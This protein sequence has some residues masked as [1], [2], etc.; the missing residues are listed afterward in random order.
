[1]CWKNY[2]YKWYYLDVPIEVLRRKM[3]E[4]GNTVE[5]R[6]EYIKRKGRA[7]LAEEFRNDLQVREVLCPLI[8][9]IGDF[10][11]KA[12]LGETLLKE[13]LMDEW[14]GNPIV[15]EVNI[16]VGALA[17]ACGYEAL[18]DKLIQTGLLGLFIAGI[19]GAL[20]TSKN[21]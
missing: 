3:I 10:Q 5:S 14:F 7:G 6:K 4:W 19:L 1:V 2:L 17:D 20:L 16:V 18:G 12:I 11:L 9:R 8:K 21:T 13:G 15:G